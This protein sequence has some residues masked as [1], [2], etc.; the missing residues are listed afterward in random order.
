MRRTRLTILVF[1]MLSMFCGQA[2]AAKHT[3]RLGW[4]TPADHMYGVFAKRFAELAHTYTNGDI[5]VKLFPAGQLGTEDGAFKSLQMGTVSAYIIT[6][7]NLSPHYELMDVFALPYFFKDLAQMQRALASPVA[8]AFFEDMHKATGVA[9]LSYGPLDTR[10]LYNTK[11][12]INSIA[13]FSGLKYRVPK[14]SVMIDTFRAFGA[15]P[16]PLAWSET[17]SALQTGTVDGGDNGTQVIL[18]MRFYEMAKHLTVLDHFL[19][20]SPLLVGDKFLKKLT[21][22]QTAALYKAAS[23]A[24]DYINELNLADLEKVRNELQQKGMKV[25][26]PEKQPFIEAANKV[27]ATFIKEKGPKFEKVLQEFRAIQ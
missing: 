26:R 19:A 17:P 25:T 2:L 9:V 16:V 22:E 11:K 12:P 14:N 8:K 10:D 6:M 27:H 21:P 24:G 20:F 23:E 1:V 3:M 7:S 15:E 5:E 4:A 18:Q 13:D